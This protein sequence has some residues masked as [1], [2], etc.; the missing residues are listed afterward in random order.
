M[1]R[2]MTLGRPQQRYDHRLR[3]LVQR[4]GDLTI[5]NGLGVPRST[6]REWLRT[7]PTV[8]VSLAV[9]DLTERELRQEV[10]KLRQRVQKLA[11]LL[12][13][14]LVL[15]RVSGFTLAGERLP[16]RPDKLR[17]LRAIDQARAC[18]PLRALLRLLRLSP[19][20]FHVWQRRHTVWYSTTS[21]RVRAS[22]HRLTPAEI[23]GPREP[24]VGRGRRTTGPRWGQPIRGL[25]D[26]SVTQY[27]RVTTD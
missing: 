8:V 18:I 14:A 25:R 3:E 11:A 17:I 6:S 19:S 9:A 16:D 20:R 13:L 5:A 27:S 24:H 21:H 10:L 1:I 7:P 4:T 15:L 26:V 22:P 2:R 23:Y 12:R